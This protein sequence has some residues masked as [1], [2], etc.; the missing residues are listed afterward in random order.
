MKLT[1]LILAFGSLAAAEEFTFIGTIDKLARSEISIKTPRGSFKIY[2][3]DKTELTKDRSYH[4]FSPVKTGDEISV[5]CQPDSAGKLIAIKVWANAVGFPATVT[6][7]RGEEIEVAG[8][9]S[10]AVGGG[11]R[12]IVRLYPDTVFGTNRADVVVGQRLRIVGLD[13]GNGAVDAARIALYNTD[14]PVVGKQK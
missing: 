1:L 8:E 7:L 12:K 9:S 2:A 10:D 6:E 4:D 11:Q 3:D 5:R 14:V 13:V